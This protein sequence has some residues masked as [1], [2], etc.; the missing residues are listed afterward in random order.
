MKEVE[1]VVTGARGFIGSH[2]VARLAEKKI[3]FQLV[4][5]LGNLAEIDWLTKNY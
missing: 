5:A 4:S 1:V 2:L 3:P